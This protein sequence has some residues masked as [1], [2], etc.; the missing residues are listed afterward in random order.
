MSNESNDGPGSGSRWD[1]GARAG[2]YD[3][4]WQKLIDQGENPHGEVDL[5]Q[6]FEPASVLDAG[7]GTGR[8]A[9]ELAARGVDVVGVDLD[10][11]MLGVAREKAPEVEWVLADL[12]GLDLGRSFDVVVMAGNIVLFVAPGT[13][14]QVVGGAA[15]HVARGGVLI[16]G[17]SL[18]RGVTVD[19]WEAWIRDAGL[20][21]VA[22]HS[23]WGGDPHS[24][25]SD[26][27]VSVAS[28]P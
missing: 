2:S 18:G 20:E 26:Y 7:C 28:R 16:A 24:P 1:G 23:T 3:N 19:Q 13:E 25:N 4:A 17:F 5:V 15:A 6:R 27:L 8:V 10:A 12:A 14:A 11:A 21:P 22:R 9:I